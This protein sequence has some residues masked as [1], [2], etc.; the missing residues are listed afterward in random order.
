MYPI[1]ND[2]QAPQPKPIKRQTSRPNPSPP[3]I[4][5][6]IRSRFHELKH[7]LSFTF[8]RFIVNPPGIRG[9]DVDACVVVVVDILPFLSCFLRYLYLR[10]LVGVTV[11]YEASWQTRLHVRGRLAYYRSLLTHRH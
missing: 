3:P 4:L 10:R 9:D 7:P 1:A 6:G 2:Q 5:Y 8:F 11:V